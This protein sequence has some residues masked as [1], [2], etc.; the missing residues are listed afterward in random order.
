MGSTSL[1]SVGLEKGNRRQEVGWVGRQGWIWEKWR[2]TVTMI[3]THCE[4]EL[5]KTKREKIR[6]E[7][8]VENQYQGQHRKLPSSDTQRDSFT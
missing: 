7:K 6:T 5:I 3:K 1:T 4:E 2:R 8:A